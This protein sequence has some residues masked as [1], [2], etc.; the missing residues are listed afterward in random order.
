MNMTEMS[1]LISDDRARGVF[2]VNRR[3]F[4]DPEIPE[5]EGR[6]V[7]DRSWPYAGY[8][9]EIATCHPQSRWPSADPGSRRLRRDARIFERAPALA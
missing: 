3:V 4:T 7:F 8:E 5:L 2:R 9:S 1:D 6:E